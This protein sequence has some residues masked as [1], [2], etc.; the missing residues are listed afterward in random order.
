MKSCVI[1]HGLGSKPDMERI[2][3]LKNSGYIVISEFFD[4]EKEWILDKGKSLFEKE[5]NKINKI[6]LIIGISFGGYLAYQLSKATGIDVLLINPALDRNKS[7]SKI[8]NFDIPEYSLESNIEIFFGEN[9]I[10]IPMEYTKDYLSEKNE[11]FR[12]HI[13]EGMA[14]RIE[15]NFKHII[16]NS[17]LS[18]KIL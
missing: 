1:Y 2:E 5:L 6:N 14:H 7:K 13:I 17:F 4:Y 3:I 12:Y 11:D 9:D 8:K 15:N 10:I 18:K 16:L